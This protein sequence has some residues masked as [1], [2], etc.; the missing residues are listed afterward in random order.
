M[1]SSKTALTE[2]GTALGLLWDPEQPWPTS[3]ES[4]EIP[5]IAAEV[6]HPVV[7]P[8]LAPGARD[9]D[10]LL[11][12]LSNGRAFR[13]EVLGGRCPHLV[14]WTG[15]DKSVWPSEIPRDLTVDDVWFIQA[16]HDS[17]CV[18]NTSPFAVFEMLLFDTDTATH[19]SWY[20][21]VAPLELQAY[22]EAV[23]LATAPGELPAEVGALDRADRLLLKGLMRSGH[24]PDPTEQATYAALTEAVSTRTAHHWLA[25]LSRATPGQRTRLV[26]RM[27]RVAGGPYWLLGSKGAE[28]LRLRVC[29]T[30]AWRQRFELRGLLAEAGGAGQPQVNW[31]ADVLDRATR[32]SVA[33]DGFC[34]VRW[35]HGK[36]QGS[37]ECKVQVTTPLHHLPGYDPM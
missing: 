2:L 19:E 8:A 12:A 3:V 15:A 32:R 24:E 28:P 30:R 10:L 6:W 11:A 14:T 21:A 36:L 31:R 17:T 5:G 4:L 25:R 34:E 27:L 7:L 9:R 37:P 26:L 16:K 33:V 18:L 20:E 13:L 29:D 35:S 1:A 22:Y 23:R